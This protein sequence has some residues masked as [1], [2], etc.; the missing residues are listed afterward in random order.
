MWKK[1]AIKYYLKSIPAILINFNWYSFPLLFIKK[2]ILIKI[3]D[4]PHFYVSNFMDIWTLKEVVVDK[5]YETIKKLDSDTTVVDIGAGIGDFA[6]Y[7]AQKARKVI[8]Y[9]CDD[10]RISLMRKNLQLNKISNVMLKNTKAKSLRQI[11]QGVGICNF[12]K[13]DC[14]GGEYD[15]F[16][17]A[18]RND[19]NKIE[20]IA[21]EAHKFDHKMEKEFS[22]LINKLKKNNFAVETVVNSVHSYICFVFA[23][24]KKPKKL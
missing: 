16:R 11:M 17:N 21:M 5:Q 24:K 7:A 8:A 20:Y 10:E 3:K 1:S 19:L 4:K 9:E 13:I 2:P 23:N 18:K 15:I 14:E 22:S 6:I 12:F